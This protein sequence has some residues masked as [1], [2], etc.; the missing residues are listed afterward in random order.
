MTTTTPAKTDR[1]L[2]VPSTTVRPVY[3]M[4]CGTKVKEEGEAYYD[5][6][7]Q[8][9]SCESAW[10]TWRENLLNDHPGGD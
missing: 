6:L 5:H 4:F 9:K 10:R 3:C 2:N 8:S 1:P 7:R